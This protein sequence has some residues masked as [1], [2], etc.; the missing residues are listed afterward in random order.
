MLCAS[1]DCLTI[2][3]RLAARGTRKDVSESHEMII[4]METIIKQMRNNK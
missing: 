1:Y 4:G 3:H 2:P